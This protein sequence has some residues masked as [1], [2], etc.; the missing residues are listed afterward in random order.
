[1]L[2]VLAQKSSATADLLALSAQVEDRLRDDP[3]YLAE[4]AGWA[5][6]HDGRG[7]PGRA[8]SSADRSGRVPARDF[9]AS[10]ASPDGDRPRGDYEVQSTLIVLSTADDQPADRFAAGRALQRAALALTA[11][12]LG[13]GLAGQLVED[14]DTRA[15][16]AELLGIDGR[17]VQQVLR[18]GR[19]PADLVAGRS[20]RL[21]LRA[22]LS[23]AR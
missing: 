21:P 16:A 12:G 13:T 17:T 22:V 9:S 19:P 18:V 4:V 20:G 1:M 8:H 23:Q 3:A 14:P 11:D 6:R 5:H 10:P 15:R 2:A 7:I